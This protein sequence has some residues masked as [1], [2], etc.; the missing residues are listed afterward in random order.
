[1]SQRSRSAFLCFSNLAETGYVLYEEN[2]RLGARRQGVRHGASYEL[3]LLTQ[4]L[5]YR[6]SPEGKAMSRDAL[7]D[8]TPIDEQELKAAE[9]CLTTLVGAVGTE[10]TQLMDWGWEFPDDGRI[11]FA[12]TSGVGADA[13][14]VRLFA[15]LDH[16]EH[17]VFELDGGPA[18][19]EDARAWL[20]QV[21]GDRADRE[22]ALLEDLLGKLQDQG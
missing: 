8:Q 10:L 4:P 5:E 12:K 16:K 2:G 11:S 15:Y 3:V 21:E 7:L 18:D 6:T 9:T 19:R 17:V 14:V 13:D 22:M 20:Q 1:M